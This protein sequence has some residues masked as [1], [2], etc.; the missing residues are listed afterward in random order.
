[1]KT[2]LV[3]FKYVLAMKQLQ[4]KREILE[5]HWKVERMEAILEPE[6]RKD[7]EFRERVRLFSGKIY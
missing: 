6:R 1:M 3:Y 2:D 5:H 4:S 7:A